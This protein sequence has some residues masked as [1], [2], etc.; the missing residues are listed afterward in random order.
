MI[1][2]NTNQ[3][4]RCR[5]IHTIAQ[6]TTSEI[7]TNVSLDDL[8]GKD[9]RWY[10]VD[11]DSPS[12]EEAALLRTHFRFDDLSID[13]CLERLERPKVDYYDTYNFFVF[14]ALDEKKMEPIELDLFISQNYIVTFHKP[15]LK[16]IECTRQKI[17]DLSLQKEGGPYFIAYQILDEIVDRYFPVVYKIEDT[18]NDLDIQSSDIGKR[19]L[20]ER[21]FEIRNDLLKLRRIVNTM[22]ELL[23]RILGSEHLE[24]F[25]DKRHHFNDVYDHLLQLSDMIESNRDLTADAR[26]NYLSVNSHKMNRIMTIL[27]VVTSIFIPLTFIAGIYGMNFHNMPELRWRYG[28]FIILGIMAGIGIAMFLWFKC[29]GWFDMKK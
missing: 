17:L 11:F 18:L 9:I 28:Y 15:A 16:E 26:D 23:Y 19:N 1:L 12:D 21:I 4:E 8:S 7:L 29:K 20:I 13:D 6:T 10:W 27:T 22:K 25:R 3:W 14:Y 5:L 24:G 2:K